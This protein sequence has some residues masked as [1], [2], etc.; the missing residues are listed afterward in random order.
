MLSSVGRLGGLFGCRSGQGV[1]HGEASCAAARRIVRCRFLH[2]EWPV[3]RNRQSGAVQSSA[4][5]EARYRSRMPTPKEVLQVGDREVT[6]SNP[7]KVYLPG[8]RASPSS[9][10]CATTS[11][12]RTARS[13][14]PAAGRWRSSA[15]STAAAKRGVLPEAGAGQPAGLAPHGHADLPDRAGRPT[16]SSS[17]KRRA[18]PGSSTSAAST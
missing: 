6:I 2:D 4:R 12:W 11:P 8:R 17:T 3:E 16:R 14:A 13:P 5:V 15:S 1:L 10:S 7:S 18:S 9:T